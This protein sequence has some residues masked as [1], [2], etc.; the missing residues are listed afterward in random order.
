MR[1]GSFLTANAEATGAMRL[2][3]LLNLSGLFRRANMNQLFN[4]GS[5]LTAQGDFELDVA[6]CA[7]LNSQL[8]G[9]ADTLILRAIS[10]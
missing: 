8:R 3:S 4:Q 5:L 10:I 6:L 9:P 1:T 2:L 7:Y